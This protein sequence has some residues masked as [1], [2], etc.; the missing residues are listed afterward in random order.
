MPGSLISRVVV[1]GAQRH[2]QVV[3][4]VGLEVEFGALAVGLV[5][6]D[7]PRCIAGAADGGELLVLHFVV[8]EIEVQLRASVPQV[9][10]H[11]GFVGEC[12]FR[13]RRRIDRRTAQAGCTMAPRKPVATRAYRLTSSLSDQMPLR[14]QLTLSSLREAVVGAGSANRE[15][16]RHA[17]D[18]I[19][20]VVGVAHA[21]AHLE[22]VR[23]LRSQR[24]RTPPRPC[25]P[26]WRA[27]T[28][29]ER[30]RPA[31]RS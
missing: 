18:E 16:F 14:S 25:C 27:G 28:G 26:G 12:W 13:D 30:R 21:G 3:G 17:R 7:Q 11:A 15:A 22:R 23:E 6:V 5:G 10:L 20:L 8:E 29:S 31:C 4:D 2:E 1:A 24:R 19:L 9:G